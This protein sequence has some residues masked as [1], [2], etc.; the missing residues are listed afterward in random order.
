[1]KSLRATILSRINPSSSIE[2]PPERMDQ[3]PFKN[4]LDTLYGAIGRLGFWFAK[5]EAYHR[6][7]Y[8]H[9]AETGA[10]STQEGALYVGWMHRRINRGPSVIN[11]YAGKAPA[12]SRASGVLPN[13]SAADVQIIRGKE[14]GAAMVSPVQSQTPS[15]KNELLHSARDGRRSSHIATVGELIVAYNLLQSSIAPEVSPIPINA[16]DTAE[17]LGRMGLQTAALQL[18]RM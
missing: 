17:A 16:E 12:D 13:V 14:Q 4:E 10:L 2:I 6:V 8:P 15:A 3:S 5:R 18:R 7:I 9:L 11:I 1:M